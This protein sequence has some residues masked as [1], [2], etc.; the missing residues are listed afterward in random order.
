MITLA[1][2]SLIF[3]TPIAQAKGEELETEI[4]P[5]SK[6]VMLDWNDVGDRYEVY[7]EGKLVWKGHD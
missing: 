6:E 4:N 7:S 3:T 2:M 5:K 1:S